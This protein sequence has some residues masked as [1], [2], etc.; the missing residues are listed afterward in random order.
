[1]GDTVLP[2][3][4]SSSNLTLGDPRRSYYPVSPKRKWWFTEPVQGEGH[5]LEGGPETRVA[6]PKV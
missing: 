5:T 4:R 1:M 3:L 6:D 2:I